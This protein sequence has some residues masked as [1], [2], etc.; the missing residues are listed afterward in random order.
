VHIH[1]VVQPVTAEQMAEFKAH[2]PTLQVAMFLRGESPGES[3]IDRIAGS[4]ATRSPRCDPTVRMGPADEGS[5]R[6]GRGLRRRQGEVVPAAVA[7]WWWRRLDEP[8][9][10]LEY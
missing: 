4:P 10:V 2:G 6:R 5:Q 3:E 9:C 8:L 1:Y 7:A